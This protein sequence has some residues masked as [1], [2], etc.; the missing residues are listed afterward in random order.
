MLFL[1]FLEMNQ[2]LVDEDGECVLDNGL[3]LSL[4]LSIAKSKP[5]EQAE[6]IQNIVDTLVRES[7]N[8]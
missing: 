8:V 7:T 3:L 1:K 5:E 4:V 2:Y 6:V